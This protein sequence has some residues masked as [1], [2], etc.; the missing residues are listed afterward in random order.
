MLKAI[1]LALICAFMAVAPASHAQTIFPAID[2]DA[3]LNGARQAIARL[4]AGR[5]AGLVGCYNGQANGWS[6][7]LCLTSNGDVASIRVLQSGSGIVCDL[8]DGA[9][10]QQGDG[11][12][13]YAAQPQRT[14]S[15]GSRITHAEGMC[16]GSAANLNCLFSVYEREN[17]FY[18]FG[19][20][21][22]PVNGQLSMR[23]E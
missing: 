18:L 7:R 17:V 2:E 20:A 3:G 12:Y 6:A 15:D 13:L 14:C 16:S 9:A 21:G 5:L 11:F 8:A 1:K 19:A 10:R 4:P 23:R 22:D